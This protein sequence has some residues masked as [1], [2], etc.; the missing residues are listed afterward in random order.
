MNNNQLNEM[1][2]A[3][4][5]GNVLKELAKIE[6]KENRIFKDTEIK[7]IVKECD[8]DNIVRK[9]IDFEKVLLQNIEYQN[10]HKEMLEF[11]DVFEK[12]KTEENKEKLLQLVEKKDSVYDKLK[13]NFD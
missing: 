7:R 2:K 10:A 9:E 12:D 11:F 1:N 6:L 5:T 3:I 13:A 8:I 4:K